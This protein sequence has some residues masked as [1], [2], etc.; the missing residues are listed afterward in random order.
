VRAALS[1][2][3]NSAG[4]NPLSVRA[5]V[6][7]DGTPELLI[8]DE[9]GKDFFGEGIAATAVADF[10]SGSRTKD[11]RVSINSPGGLV[12]EGLAIYNML[13]EH[14]GKVTTRNMGIAGS[15]ASVILMAGDT[16]EMFDNAMMHVHK[17]WGVAVGNDDVMKEAAG[18]LAEMDQQI[19][20]VY[21]TRSGK[22][23]DS[24]Y[25]LMKG[26]GKDDGTT[27]NATEAKEW[28]LIDK[29]VSA[30]GKSKDK[31]EAAKDTI[32]ATATIARSSKLRKL[33]LDEISACDMMQA[34]K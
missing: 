9:I 13:A 11:I 10:L 20:G 22:R 18:F 15:I 4:I 6:A 25:N 2:A 33:L 12:F 5:E 19:A 14:Q 32:D 34:Y 7:E 31:P 16:I 28:G 17:A 24:A 8:F 21:A 26:S 27:L 30:K 3:A 23:K 1:K 29:I